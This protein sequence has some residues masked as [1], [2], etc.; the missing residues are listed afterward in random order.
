[1]PRALRNRVLQRLEAH[2]HSPGRTTG[3]QNK[4]NNQPQD[5]T[6]REELRRLRE[7]VAKYKAAEEQ[8][9]QQVGSQQQLRVETQHQEGNQQQQHQPVDTQHQVGNQQQSSRGSSMDGKR[10]A[11]GLPAGS[12]TDV[13][14]VMRM[15]T[16]GTIAGASLLE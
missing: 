8:Q 15:A 5:E 11:V 16:A 2:N 13:A 7:E 9:R 10:D 3:N 14:G 12:N 4:D 1:M 6:E